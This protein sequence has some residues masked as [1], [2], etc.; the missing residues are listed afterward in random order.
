M[1]AFAFFMH[2]KECVHVQLFPFVTLE[3]E[4]ASQHSLHWQ[5]SEANEFD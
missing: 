4:C 2:T 3:I 1:E 5:G